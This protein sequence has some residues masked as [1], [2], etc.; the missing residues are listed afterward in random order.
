MGSRT[1]PGVAPA[2]E[3]GTRE[4]PGRMRRSVRVLAV[5]ALA[6]AIVAVVVLVR[7]DSP[8]VVHAHFTDASQLVKGDRVQ[9][10][11]QVAGEVTDV[12][13]AANG[14]ADVTLH[15]AKGFVPLREGT[16]ASVRLRSL[17]G[18]ANLYV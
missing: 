6:A 9:V 1:A 2:R 14:D 18:V 17:L 15:I 12:Q 3:A 13:L 5:A 8:Y 11:G 10:S 7:D 4:V 16:T